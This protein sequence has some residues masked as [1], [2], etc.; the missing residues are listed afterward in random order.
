MT[1]TVRPLFFFFISNAIILL[2]RPSF[3]FY[4]ILLVVNSFI[5]KVY[6]LEGAVMVCGSLIQWLRDQ[7]KLRFR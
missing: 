2:F 4:S 1:G 6:A 5:N 7:V 3:L